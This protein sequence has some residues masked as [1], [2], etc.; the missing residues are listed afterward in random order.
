MVYIGGIHHEQGHPRHDP[1]ANVIFAVRMT[2]DV[3]GYMMLFDSE[4]FQA[5]DEKMLFIGPEALEAEI[6]GE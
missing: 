4:K 5:G 6:D 1:E 3:C 2:C